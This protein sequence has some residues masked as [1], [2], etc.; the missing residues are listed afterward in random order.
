PS[1]ST[2]PPPRASGTQ[3]PPP[4]SYASS[5]L[6]RP[7][8][9]PPQTERRPGMPAQQEPTPFYSG[10]PAPPPVPLPH[11]AVPPSRPHPAIA[12]A[13]APVFRAP[14]IRAH[15]PLAAQRGV[16]AASL[17]AAEAPVMPAA[18]RNTPIRRRAVPT[19]IVDLLWYAE[20]APQRVRAHE[21]YT[22][23]D[24]AQRRE[25]RWILNGTAE[26]IPQEE[27]DRRDVRRALT[28]LHELSANEIQ[29]SMRDAVDEDGIYVR[30]VLVVRGTLTMRFDPEDELAAMNAA[31]KPFA[32]GNKPLEDACRDIDEA[33]KP[34]ARTLSAAIEALRS[35]LVQAFVL[36]ARSMPKDYLSSAAERTLLE[37]RRYAM[38]K[39]F[40]APHLC[41]LVNPS[42]SSTQVPVYLPEDLAQQIPLLPKFDA[43]L[44]V[45]PHSKQDPNDHGSIALSLLALGRVTPLS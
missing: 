25:D 12:H 41:A 19:E 38:R 37:D 33:V 6:P 29:T 14:P 18:R 31:A 8:D 36:A 27:R 26:R 7:S 5:H 15:D 1:P 20:D 39:V 4:P 10:A 24:D 9:L 13:K 22:R 3:P 2:H 44:L 35:R 16:A 23:L 11:P 40:G 45:E 42:G 43:K 32:A 30:P 28:R 34:D 21:G 17:A